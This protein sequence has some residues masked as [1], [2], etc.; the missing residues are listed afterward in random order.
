M[1]CASRKKKECVLLDASVLMRV[2]LY[3]FCLCFFASFLLLELCSNIHMLFPNFYISPPTQ[4]F[5]P[6]DTLKDIDVTKL[7]H[8]VFK[9]TYA[10]RIKM[11]NNNLKNIVF[12]K[13]S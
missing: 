4:I 3:I 11:P 5:Y 12:D 13:F 1:R 9:L 2:L 8:S 7:Y 6:K 10:D